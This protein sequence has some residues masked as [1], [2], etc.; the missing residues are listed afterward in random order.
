MTEK[1]KA[2]LRKW[3]WADFELYN[4]FRKKLDKL[5]SEFG[6]DAMKTEVKVLQEA[7]RELD[8]TCHSLYTRNAQLIGTVFYMA[9]DNVKG[10]LLDPKCTLFAISEPYFFQLIHYRQRNIFNFKSNFR[11]IDIV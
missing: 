5:I 6:Q 9:S 8:K 10:L 7:N 3:L 1:T 11:N 4:H 2:K